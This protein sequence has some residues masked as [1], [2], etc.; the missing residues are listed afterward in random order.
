[1]KLNEPDKEYF[2]EI[3]HYWQPLRAFFC[4]HM[5]KDRKLV[6]SKYP[7]PASRELTALGDAQQHTKN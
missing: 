3:G 1:M 2:D 5:V 7:K 4:K 6:E